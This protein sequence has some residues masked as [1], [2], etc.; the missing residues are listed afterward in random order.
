MD[1][2]RRGIPFPPSPSRTRL[3]DHTNGIEER[4]TAHGFHHAFQP[5][6]QTT[7]HA[8]KRRSRT[9]IQRKS[10]LLRNKRKVRPSSRPWSA[11]KRFISIRLCHH[12]NETGARVRDTAV[13]NRSLRPCPNKLLCCREDLQ[14]A[15]FSSSPAVL[16][17][18]GNAR[19]LFGLYKIA[20]R[21]AQVGLAS[22]SNS[23]TMRQREQGILP[24]L[25]RP[26]D[27]EH[28][29]QPRTELGIFA[30][31]GEK[32]EETVQLVNFL[33]VRCRF[34]LVLQA[35]GEGRRIVSARSAHLSPRRTYGRMR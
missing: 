27:M 7:N 31:C 35:L 13:Q 19:H 11:R 15:S 29:I 8:M 16:R 18:V 9:S 4:S 6:R 17:F 10:S 12:L 22:W 14:R 24:V 34:R 33:Q 28:S 32:E 1:D 5:V 20:N 23:S 2:A 30:V 25:G 3:T 21:K 26:Q